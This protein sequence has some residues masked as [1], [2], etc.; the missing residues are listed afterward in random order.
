VGLALRAWPGEHVAKCLVFYHPDDEP[1]LRDAQLGRLAQ[2]EDA[3]AATGHELLVE[4]LPPGGAIF[5]AD[6][7]ARAMRQIYAA[8][9]A[10]DWWKL[11][12]SADDRSWE[13]VAA[14]VAEHDPH[15]RGVLVLGLESS[16][17]DLLAGFRA[18]ARHPICKGFAVGRWIFGAAANEWFAG[19][20]DD[21][22][23]VSAVSMRYAKLAGEWRA[24]QEAAGAGRPVN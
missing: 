21:A 16:E 18:A 6:T 8:G 9:V 3:C 5:G 2:L 12:P 4:I 14:A 20:L 7:V 1:T 10:P 24:A 13:A 19:R 15:C 23:V 17:S 22:A 11:P